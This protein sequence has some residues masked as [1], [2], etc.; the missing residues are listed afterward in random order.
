MNTQINPEE[1]ALLKKFAVFVKAKR[2]ALGKTQADLAKEIF[3][4]KEQRKFI[5]A[6][7]TGAKKGLTFTTMAKILKALK[8]DINFTE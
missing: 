2:L 4:D 8:S 6:I 3:D 1:N 7:E 5:S